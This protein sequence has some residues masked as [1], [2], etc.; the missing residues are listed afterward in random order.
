MRTRFEIPLRDGRHIELGLRT[1]IVG[2]LNVTPDSF[3]DGGRHFSMTAAIEHAHKMY[4]DGADIIEVGGDS[5]RPGAS[6]LDEAEELARVLPVLKGIS[7]LSVPLAIDTYKHG[8]A[9]AAIDQGVVIVND[10][11][12]LRND[13]RLADV[14]ARTQVVLG[15]MHVRGHPATMQKQGFSEDIF[16]EIT[17]DLQVA[18]AEAERRGVPRDRIVIDPGI[19]FGKSLDQNL[20]IIKGLSRF[21]SFGLPLMIGTSRK[22]FVGRL[23]GKKEE[24]R[25]FG[26]AA[27]VAASILNGA[28]IVRVHD[29]KEMKDVVLVA[30][31]IAR[32]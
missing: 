13:P 6:A 12:A 32:G 16:K 26:T 14:V 18:I 4:E 25:V 9:E 10:V 30:D 3:S 5:T 7:G 19:G 21:E 31:A 23:T 20:A 28:H 8:V 1:L 15:D 27:S 2:V 22:G 17:D 29:V 24:E 11:S